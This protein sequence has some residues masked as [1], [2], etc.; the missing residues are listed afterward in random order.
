MSPRLPSTIT[1]R[2]ASRAYAATRSNA[3]M[4]SPP[5]ISKNASWGL[6]PTQWGATAS[7]IPQQNRSVA[8]AAAGRPICALPRSSSGS[9]SSRG[10]SPT[11]SWL[12]F[13]PI[14]AATR[15]AKK[16]GGR[17]PSTGG[18]CGPR[19]DSEEAAGVSETGAALPAADGLLQRAPGR[20]L[21]HRGR[22][23]VHLLARVAGVHAHPRL[24]VGGCEL[25]E[26]CEVDLI[27]PPER[28]RDRFEHGVDGL[29]RLA[30]AEPASLG[31]GVDELLLG[32]LG[33]HPLDVVD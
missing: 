12:R 25:P 3:A 28:L 18:E 13:S 29:G 8:S 5:R 1:S 14:A 17:T 15:S 19:L 4:P 22:R 6:T 10:S 32:K 27:T 21:R 7:T 2:P 31:N 23:D 20:E 11:T 33:P 9:R 16:A 26:S 24:A 30:L